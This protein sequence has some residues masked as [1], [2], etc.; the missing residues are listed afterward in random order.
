MKEYISKPKKAQEQDWDA[1]LLRQKIK[2]HLHIKHHFHI[3]TVH[4]HR[5]FCLY[6]SYIYLCGLLCGS[7]I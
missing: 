6:S 5:F 2:Y 1:A 7:A 4:K 3:T